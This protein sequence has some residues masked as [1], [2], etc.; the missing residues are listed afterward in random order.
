MA[1]LV[2]SLLY[3]HGTLCLM[4]GTHVKKKKKMLGVGGA[5]L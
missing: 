2:K 4:P 5:R 3:E 1:Q